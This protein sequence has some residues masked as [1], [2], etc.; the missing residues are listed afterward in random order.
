MTYLKKIFKM[1][2][3]SK[4]TCWLIWTLL[5]PLLSSATVLNKGAWI[6]GV[7][8]W[9][10]REQYNLMLKRTVLAC[11]NTYLVA[12]WRTGSGCGFVSP[13]LELFQGWETFPSVICHKRKKKKKS[14]CI[15]CCCWGRSSRKGDHWWWPGPEATGGFSSLP[16]PLKVDFSFLP[17]LQK[18][19]K[20]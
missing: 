20:G 5:S 11:F 16:L 2:N 12:P 8:C 10:Q 14:K 9:Y 4:R 6:P 1:L 19:Q 17:H 3:F 7:G 13:T 18:L 15:R